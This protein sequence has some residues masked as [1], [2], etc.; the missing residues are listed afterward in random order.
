MHSPDIHFVNLYSLGSDCYVV[1]AGCMLCGPDAFFRKAKHILPWHEDE[2]EDDGEP[3]G[4]IG[5]AHV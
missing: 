3:Q 1:P 5:R 4:Q 2:D